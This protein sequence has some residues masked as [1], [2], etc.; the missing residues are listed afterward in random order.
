MHVALMD[1]CGIWIVA[2]SLEVRLVRVVIFR[3]QNAIQK[4]AQNTILRTFLFL[5]IQ[6]IEELNDAKDCAQL[7]VELKNITNYRT[8][9][10]PRRIAKDG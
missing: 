8:R 6:K 4:N 10:E 5:E 2:M 7:L 3:A 1:T 9:H